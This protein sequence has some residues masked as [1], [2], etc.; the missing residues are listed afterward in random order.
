M[1]VRLS[2]AGLARRVKRYLLKKALGFF[3]ATT[4]GFEAMLLREL[5]QLP[6]ISIGRQFTG[7]IEFSGPLEL[8]YHAGLRLRT[9]NRIVMRI[10]VFTA[11]SY[12]ELYNK[13]SHIPWELYC[14]FCGKIGGEASASSSR[15]HHTGNITKAVFDACRDHMSGLGVT[16]VRDD[17]AA[18]RFL[19]RF[20]EAQCTI[21]IDASGPLLYKR[22]Y[23]QDT[24][25]APIRET[26]AAG[27]LELSDCRRFPV[28]AD[29]LCGSGTFL[30]EAALL[31]AGRPPGIGRTF[32]F[33]EWPSHRPGLWSR[34]CRNAVPA[35]PPVMPLLLGFDIS[36]SAIAASRSNAERAGIA[37]YLSLSKGDCLDFNRDGSAGKSGLLIANLPYGK[38]AHAGGDDLNDFYRKLGARLRESCRGWH[39]GFVVADPDFAKIAGIP[40]K[41]TMQ[42]INGGLD[43]WFVQGMIA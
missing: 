12:P 24:A 27:L 5:Q 41:S 33:Q 29:P 18:I 30:I 39:Y 38:R 16:V 43:V 22:G 25:H 19:V 3:A 21:S 40:A 6:G 1:T 34:I 14:G 8:V 35:A 9:A 2:E 42:F 7:G 31:A 4:P 15:L 17:D 20:V 23:R 26:I 11:R 32:A 28:I 36:E 13:A 10:D 37:E